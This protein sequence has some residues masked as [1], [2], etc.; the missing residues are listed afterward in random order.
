VSPTLLHEFLKCSG[1][2]WAPGNYFDMP[3]YF[4]IGMGGDTEMTLAG[5]E[6]IGLPLDRCE[7]TARKPDSQT[8]EILCIM[9]PHSSYRGILRSRLASSQTRA[10]S[11]A[12]RAPRS[13]RGGQ[14]FDPAQVHHLSTACLKLEVVLNSLVFRNRGSNVGG[15]AAAP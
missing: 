12:G 10:C 4:R 11:S 9:K 8:G 1:R 15:I 14:R 7:L 13:Q 5:F 3:L 6:P 2:V